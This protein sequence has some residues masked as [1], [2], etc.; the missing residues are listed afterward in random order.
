[1]LVLSTPDLASSIWKAMDAEQTNPYWMD[2]ERYHNFSRDRIVGLLKDAGFE[3][4]DFAIPARSKA[5]IELY[6][7]R[8]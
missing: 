1:V 4:V 3:V 2:L 8:K 5:Q 6:A 7:V